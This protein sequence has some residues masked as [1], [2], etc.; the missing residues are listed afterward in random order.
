VAAVAY[1]TVSGAAT[2]SNDAVSWPE[3]VP[4]RATWEGVAVTAA[5][6]NSCLG[7]S[8]SIRMFR[9]FQALCFGVLTLNPRR[10]KKILHWLIESRMRCSLEQGRG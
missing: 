10:V 1:S 8:S 2:E 6:V 4:G 7:S 9:R 3:W 5:E